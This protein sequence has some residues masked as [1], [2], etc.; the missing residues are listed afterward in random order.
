M[1]WGTSKAGFIEQAPRE[2][3]PKTVK[4][5]IRAR[6]RASAQRIYFVLSSLVHKLQ[7]CDSKIGRLFYKILD[8]H[9]SPNDVLTAGRGFG[10]VNLQGASKWKTIFSARK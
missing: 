5:R 8:T 7:T 6:I 3:E 1:S 10:A 4:S 9:P 2:P